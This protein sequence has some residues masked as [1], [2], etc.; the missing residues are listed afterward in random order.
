LVYESV[1]MVVLI[2]CY[3]VRLILWH[4]RKFK[5]ELSVHRSFTCVRY[6]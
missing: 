3:L 6:R 4:H 1:I 2:A 5:S